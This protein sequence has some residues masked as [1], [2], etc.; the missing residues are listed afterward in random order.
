[1]VADPAAGGVIVD[2]MGLPRRFELDRDAAT[3]TV[4]GG[5]TCVAPCTCGRMCVCCVNVHADVDG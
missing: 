2:L 4:D 1:M 3:V 5:T